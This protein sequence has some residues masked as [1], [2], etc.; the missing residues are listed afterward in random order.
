MP[1][2]PIRPLSAA[3]LLAVL[4]CGAAQAA[5][6]VVTHTSDE[7]LS[8]AMCTSPGFEPCTLRAAIQAANA[9]PGADAIHFDFSGS[10]Q[11]IAPASALPAI[12]D[13]VT[14]DGYADMAGI[15]NTLLVGH[16]AEIRVRIDGA[17]AGLAHGLVFA[18][19]ASPSVLRGL[20]ITRFGGHG[21]RVVGVPNVTIAGNFIGTDGT[22]ADGDETAQLANGQ[23]GVLIGNG[24]ASAMVGGFNPADRNLIVGN[25]NGMAVGLDLNPGATLRGNY[26]GT[27]RAGTSRRGTGMGISIDGNQGIGSGIYGNVIGANGWGLYIRNGSSRVALRGNSI[28]VGADGAANIAG[29]ASGV[30]ITDAGQSLESPSFI[31]V[32]G[33]DPGEPNTIANW[34]L[35]GIRAQRNNASPYM[36]MLT[37]QRNSIYSNGALGIE[38]IDNY[39]S[40]GT[41]PGQPAPAAINDGQNPPAIQSAIGDAQGTTVQ[42]SFTGAPGTAQS[43]EVFA[44]TACDASGWGEG[45]TFVSD[46]LVNTDASGNYSGSITV[47]AVPAGTWL[48]VTSSRSFSGGSP[49]YAT[50]EFS[51]CVQVQGGAPVHPG[52]GNVAAIPTLGHAALALLSALVGL[53][54][55]RQRR[56]A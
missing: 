34:G 53:F 32:G 33:T 42:L 36:A 44:N 20:A 13:P 26:I 51:R 23:Y 55:L 18:P 35:N 54:G 10:P 6:F 29:S 2:T 40:Q 17:S 11:T 7:P 45:R 49:E 56:G 9:N 4:W 30:Y 14:I 3:L 24:A 1:L 46:A 37:F 27:D 47:P 15:P 28:G 8:G 41:A 19:G 22:G 39:A 16:N 50:S 38:L 48:T 31:S 12:A 52:G 25:A 21:V 5:T 43:F